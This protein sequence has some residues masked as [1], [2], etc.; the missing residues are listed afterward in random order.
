MRVWS[1]ACTTSRTLMRETLTPPGRKPSRSEKSCDQEKP[2]RLT[3][4]RGLQ[5]LA[6]LGRDALPDG[7][8]LPVEF[9]LLRAHR[10][11][12]PVGEVGLRA[13]LV[14]PAEDE[15]ERDER[16]GRDRDG[17]SPGQGAVPE[18]VVG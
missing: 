17:Q 14:V 12:L 13:R 10:L 6:L 1:P 9:L 3:S 5:G 2:L 8:G 16:D 4:A 7:V 15:D 18:R 11:H